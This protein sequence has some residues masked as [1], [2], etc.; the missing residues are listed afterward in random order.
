ML[1]WYQEPFV[2]KKRLKL[3]VAEIKELVGKEFRWR[4]FVDDGAMNDRAAELFGELQS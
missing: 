1:A 4:I 3:F 2:I